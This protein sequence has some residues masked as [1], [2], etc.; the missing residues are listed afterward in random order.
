[1]F[2]N[3][4]VKK[5]LHLE[6]ITYSDATLSDINVVFCYVFLQYHIYSELTD[7]LLRGYRGR[8]LDTC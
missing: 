7:R 6:I 2:W 8:S 4:Y 5:L 1:M 3:P